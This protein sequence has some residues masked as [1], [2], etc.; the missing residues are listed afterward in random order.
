MNQ[1]GKKV[2][3]NILKASKKELFLKTLT[4]TLIRASLLIIPIFWSKA[5]DYV[6]NKNIRLACLYVFISLIVTIGYWFFEHINQKVFYN[7]Y[8]KL[9]SDYMKESVSATQSCQIFFPEFV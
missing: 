7:L 2:T 1:K 8:N 4:S 3:F 5:V 6:S 9:Y